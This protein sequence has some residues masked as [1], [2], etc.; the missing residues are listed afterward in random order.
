MAPT[1]EK[2]AKGKS[3]TPKF[4]RNDL[5][6]SWKNRKNEY[7]LLAFYCH[8]DATALEIGTDRVDRSIRPI[9]RA[10]P[11]RTGRGEPH[12]RHWYSSPAARLLLAIWTR[13]IDET[14]RTGFCGFIGTE[15][16]VSERL[17]LDRFPATLSMRFIPKVDLC[18]TL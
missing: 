13:I 17:T 18:S 2:F 8:A 6:N 9:Q 12:H 3:R 11:P 10:V 16:Q 15:V 5:L 14:S 4:S 1:P 7:G